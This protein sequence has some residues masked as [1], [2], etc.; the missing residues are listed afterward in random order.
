MPALAAS[1]YPTQGRASGVAWM[2]GIGRLGG[3]L[4]AVL[5]GVLLQIGLETA[6]IIGVLAIPAAVAAAA[7]VYKDSARARKPAAVVVG[8]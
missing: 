4:G 1:Y 3:I 6:T 7:L 2:L 5:G 8:A